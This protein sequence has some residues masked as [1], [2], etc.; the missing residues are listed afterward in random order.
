MRMKDAQNVGTCFMSLQKRTC[1]LLPVITAILDGYH[2]VLCSVLN[3]KRK[4]ER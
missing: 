2:Y 1:S 3:W 4:W